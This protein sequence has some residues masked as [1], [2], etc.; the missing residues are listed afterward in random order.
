MGI[1][2]CATPTPMILLLIH[3][4][5]ESA[6]TLLFMVLELK[7]YRRVAKGNAR[8]RFRP[9]SHPLSFCCQ[10]AGTKTWLLFL[11]CSSSFHMTDLQMSYIFTLKHGWA[12]QSFGQLLNCEKIYVWHLPSNLCKGRP[13]NLELCK[14]F[15]PQLLQKISLMKINHNMVS[16]NIDVKQLHVWSYR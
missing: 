16:H 12:C 3:G 1:F 10:Q 11:W 13:Q 4:G 5:L 2:N 6:G 15:L 7:N 14:L 8:E 9:D